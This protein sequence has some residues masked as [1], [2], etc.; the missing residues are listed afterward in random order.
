MAKLKIALDIDG[1]LAD[2]HTPCFQTLRLNLTANDVRKWDFFDELGISREAFWDAY[3]KVWS[4]AYWLI[5]LI[6]PDA[7]TTIAKLR[8]RYEVHIISSRPKETHTGTISWLRHRGVEYDKII[9]LPPLT[10]KINFI[11]NHLCLVDDNPSFAHHPKVMLFD[12]PWNR[13][14][15]TKRRI[16]SLRELLEIVELLDAPP[17]RG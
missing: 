8:Q 7:P 10:D 13:H 9:L 17:Q 1:V 6:E 16:R 5:P 3:K 14:V 12:R 11:D 4:E 15:E 2:M